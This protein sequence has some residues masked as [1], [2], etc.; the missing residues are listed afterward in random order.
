VVNVSRCS[1]FHVN[2]VSSVDGGTLDF[3]ECQIGA[4]SD[5]AHFDG[6]YAVHGPF[7]LAGS[8]AG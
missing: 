5:P 2:L 7:F 1:F 4:V 8:V 6:T 3:S